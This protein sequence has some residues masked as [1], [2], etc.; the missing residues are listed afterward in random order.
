VHSPTTSWMGKIQR[1]KCSHGPW[2]SMILISSLPMK[3]QKV[4]GVRHL[5]SY[6]LLPNLAIMSDHRFPNGILVHLLTPIKVKVLIFPASSCYLTV[7]SDHKSPD[8]ISSIN[9]IL[10]RDFLRPCTFTSSFQV[11]DDVFKEGISMVRFTQ[12]TI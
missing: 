5:T 11:L 4:T 1:P 3:T 6:F 2:G 7:L 8:K 12:G 9:L 10:I